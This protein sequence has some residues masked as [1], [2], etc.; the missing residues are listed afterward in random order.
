MTRT[1]PRDRGGMPIRLVC[2]EVIE[3]PDTGASFTS[4]ESED[5]AIGA[6][7]TNDLV[8]HDPA[9]SRFHVALQREGPRIVVRDL[10]STNGVEIG[11]ALI[12]NGA[13]LVRPGTV[14]RLGD[15]AV[16][17]G[18]GRV[19]LVDH[20]PAEIGGIH[21]RSPPMRRL[22]SQ[23]ERVAKSDAAVLLV[24][25]SGTGKELL[26]RSLHDLGPRAS[27]PF[28]IVDCGAIP[29]ALFS[30][31]LFGHERGA[32][33][34]ADRKYI[35]AL[36]RA[37]GGTLFLD[38]VAELGPEVQSALLGALERKRIK[39][40]GSGVEVQ[41]DVRLVSATSR[42]LRSAVNAGRFRLDLYY[43]LA[44]VLLQVPALRERREDLRT[45]VDVF[46]REAG[47]REAAADLVPADEWERLATYDWPGNVRELRNYVLGT[48]ALGEPAP[49]V[50]MGDARAPD[51]SESGSVASY[52][53]ARRAALDAFERDYVSR[54]LAQ[55]EGN[56]RRAARE[57]RMDRKYLAELLKR[58]KIR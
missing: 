54:L 42:D 35:G 36:E 4:S 20:G 51:P 32:F 41:T 48:L 39:P 40:L 5:V 58:H 9:V 22:M 56:V 26:A 18:D 29:P 17:V 19:V 49:L 37:R 33:T 38:E 31:E 6:A 28:E 23:L 2:A 27:G 15:S 21:G 8:L 50:P 57:A 52:R 30:S 13:V 11:A 47:A 12:R 14:I 10:G 45:L 43:R 1:A 53:D 16:R 46:L 55:A 7:Q 3:G 25:E 24:G 44:V 34:G